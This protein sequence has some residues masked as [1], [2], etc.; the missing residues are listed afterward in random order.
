M[1]VLQNTVCM[2][3]IAE[4]SHFAKCRRSEESH[5]RRRSQLGAPL[6]SGAS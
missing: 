6:E 2:Y 3:S 4:G 5:G 1:A